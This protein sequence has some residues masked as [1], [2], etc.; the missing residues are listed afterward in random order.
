MAEKTWTICYSIKNKDGTI[1]EAAVFPGEGELEPATIKART[2]WGA[3]RK[4]EYNIAAPLRKDPQIA[5]V[6][7]WNIGIN[8]DDVFQA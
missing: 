6:V 5:E 7:I 1:Q 4:A 2:I 3:L 8:E